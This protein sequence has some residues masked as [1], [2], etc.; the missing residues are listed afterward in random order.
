VRLPL[1][2]RTRTL[3]A[4]CA[5]AAFATIVPCTPAA[6]A[7]P[8]ADAKARAAA[9]ARTAATAKGRVAA[10]QAH[11]ASVQR[12]IDALD[13]QS[14]IAAEAYN[15]AVE[16]LGWADRVAKAAAA[17][18]AAATAVL[19]HLRTRAGAVAVDAYQSGGLS[20]LSVLTDAG[21]P[22]TLLD[23][24]ATLD[25]VAHAQRTSLD[26]LAVAEHEQ[27]FAKLAAD[28]A[29][30][31]Q[32]QLTANKRRER[33]AVLAA[34]RREQQLLGQ[35]QDAQAQLV[36]QAQA[37]VAQAT[38]ARYAVDAA[39]AARALAIAK[40]Q[41]AALARQRAAQA[42][43]TS[44][45]QA[46]SARAISQG[47]SPT[48]GSASPP[49]SEAPPALGSGGAAVAVAWAYREIGKPYVWAAAGPDTFDCSGL[50]QY[51]WAKAGV[52]LGH[53]TGTQ[54]NQGHP[55][56]SAALIPG[57]LVFFGSPIHHVG[58][59]VGAGMMI[60]APH[61]GAFVREEPV[62]WPQYAGA[63]RPSG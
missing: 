54:I 13:V 50:T 21:G 52:Y 47:S 44:T 14:E 61:T 37:A 15:G 17:R 2:G 28:V 49:V 9:A 26:Q 8:V 6:V 58:I 30:A 25:A 63:V 18:L 60:D 56:S 46:A 42:A 36:A 34:A 12:Q 39:V 19:L 29:L 10:E 22:A 1:G 48:A 24:V 3:T 51:V 11:I 33:D 40:A 31:R 32:R 41:A 59:Y 57:D 55:V 43:A 27:A 38:A 62:W 20:Q 5:F 7:D 53:Y 45:F 16:Q 4:V 35:L 23:R